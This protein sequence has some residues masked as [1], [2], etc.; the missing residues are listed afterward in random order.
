VGGSGSGLSSACGEASADGGGSDCG[1][2]GGPASG[3]GIVGG[4]TS[5]AAA[6]SCGGTLGN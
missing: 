5:S 4:H 6:D 2:C 1:A 3:T